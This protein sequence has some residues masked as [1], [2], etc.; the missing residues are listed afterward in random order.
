MN[1]SNSQADTG[2]GTELVS[3]TGAMNDTFVVVIGAEPLQSEVVALIPPGARIV[4][5][6]SGTD[7]ALAA[8]LFPETVIGDFDSI[9]KSG[10]AWAKA[11][12]QLVEHPP[13]KDATDTELALQFVAQRH[14]ER[15]ILLSGG[16]D[17]LDHTMAAFGALGAPELT[18]IPDLQ[19]WWGGQYA[20]VL[21]GP[22][23]IRRAV[24]P[25]SQISLLALQG[26]CSGVTVSGTHW[27]LA[28]AD[29]SALSGHGLSN[30]A[31]SSTVQIAV[32]TGVLTIFFPSPN[33]DFGDPS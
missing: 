2:S 14:P 28:N 13:E 15:V 27:E 1:K 25:G 6:D 7:H 33:P 3:S 22:S 4:A 23:R 21:H 20:L 18:G 26:P 24:S 10:L 9:S 8:G 29:L 17:R 32:S 30:V 12:A 19:C 31:V 5:A 11:N 16:G